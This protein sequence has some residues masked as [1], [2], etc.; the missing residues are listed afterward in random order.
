MHGGMPDPYESAKRRSEEILREVQLGRL[1][2]RLRAARK[3][4]AGMGRA[5]VLMWELERGASRLLKLLRALKIPL[6]VLAT[7]S[8]AWRKP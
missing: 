6:H 4:R 7:S 2:K 8:V 1:A 3:L 5:S